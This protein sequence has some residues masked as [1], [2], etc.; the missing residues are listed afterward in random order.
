M[1]RASV[2]RRQPVAKLPPS[3]QLLQGS[4]S[5]VAAP[6][7]LPTRGTQDRYGGAELQCRLSRRGV[8]RQTSW[9]LLSGD[10]GMTPDPWLRLNPR[11]RHSR[12]R[13]RLSKRD[14]DIYL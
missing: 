9:L 4:P 13:Y 5:P 2:N 10:P 1:A 3:C 8:A 6:P 11:E 7:A 12:L 14:I